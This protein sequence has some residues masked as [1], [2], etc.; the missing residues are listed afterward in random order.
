MIN[1]TKVA[2]GAGVQSNYYDSEQDII[3]VDVETLKEVRDSSWEEFWQFS[4]AEFF[5]A[6]AAWLAVEQ[7][8]TTPSGDD[9]PILF[10]ICLLALPLSA[11]PAWAGFMQLKRRRGRIDKLLKKAGIDELD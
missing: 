4:V 3:G 9:Y 7:F 6:G 11:I 8:F 10:W 1:R 5:F 2:E